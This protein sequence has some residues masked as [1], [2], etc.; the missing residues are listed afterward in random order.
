[1]VPH[2]TLA[3]FARAIRVARPHDRRNVAEVKIASGKRRLIV[4]WVA[5]GLLLQLPLQSLAADDSRGPPLAAICAACHRLDGRDAGIPSIIGL[6]RNK[7]SAKLEAFRRGERPSQLMH[8]VA[9]SL[10]SEEI[11]VVAAYLATLRREAEP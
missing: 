11:A 7:L 3:A 4:L 10:S 5:I 1:M 9:L 2:W 6:D 8:A